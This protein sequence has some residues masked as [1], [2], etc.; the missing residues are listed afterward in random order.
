M[1]ATATKAPETAKPVTAAKVSSEPAA[2]KPAAKP[3]EPLP[4]DVLELQHAVEV[5]ASLA[6][7]EYNKAIDILKK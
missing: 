2:P 5:A 7:Q 6:V 3:V 1:P 4:S